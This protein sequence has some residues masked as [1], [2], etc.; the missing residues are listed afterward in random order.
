[1]RRM[2]LWATL[3]GFGSLSFASWAPA[4]AWAQGQPEEE[5]PPPNPY[6]DRAD[7][8][9]DDDADEDVRD[10]EGAPSP[11]GDAAKAEKDDLD[12]FMAADDDDDDDDDDDGFMAKG[13]D[14]DDDD[15]DDGGFLKDL[16][17]TWGGRIQT[18]L[19]FRLEEK[20]VG[21]FYNRASLPVG[22]E[23]NENLFGIRMNA[24][25]GSVLAVA[26]LDF[27]L[28]GALSDVKSIGDLSRGEKLDPYRFDIHR[29][30]VQVKDLVFDGLDL[31]IGQQLILWGAGDQF[32]PTNNLNADDIEDVLLF[33]EQRGN[34]MVRLDYW[35][36]SDWSI[37]GVMVPVFRPAFL[38]RSSPLALANPNRLPM[39]DESVRHRIH[40]E[41]AAGATLAGYPTVVKDVVPL[42]PDTAIENIQL[43]Y[44]IGGSIGGQDVAL[45]YYYGRHDFPV[46]INN[47]IAVAQDPMCNPDDPNECINGRLETTAFV[48][49]PRMHVYGFNMSG[50]VGIGYRLEAALVVP[51]RVE[52]GIT[53]D[54]LDLGVI[55][56]PA[57]EYDYDG[58]NRPGGPKPVVIDDTPFAKWTVGVDYTF[59]EHLY[60]NAQWVH[61]LANEYGAGDWITEGY[62][63]RDGGVTSDAGGTINCAQ[64]DRD[65]T[66]CAREILRNRIADYLVLGVDLNFLDRKLLLRLFT[67]L[68]L[69]GV[70]ETYYDTATETR[71]K[72]HHHL[73]TDEGY[74]VVLY[75]E[76]N[77]N[78][79]NGLELGAGALIQLGKD[80]GRFGA[81]EAGG[82][83]AF[84]RARFSF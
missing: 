18:D 82:S 48:H 20:A 58:D 35:L 9:D 46:P 27:V 41:N 1:M 44:R 63:V 75:P 17:I 66:K 33:G 72:K 74:G 24:N 84:T 22:I 71:V 25:Y 37:T 64:I 39:L 6:G 16:E 49:Y 69:V 13:N 31:T 43:S 10:V 76:V 73:F 62:E 11:D 38:P 42:V 52:M 12:G 2:W 50:E 59:N 19:R 55:V 32:N 21:N 81:P 51:E 78:F 28:Y 45:S 60:V 34:F 23:R 57:G 56:V 30:Y 26:E 8:T 36:D 40:A 79:G 3:L 65:G 70:T 83:L 80:T 4:V 29:L 5:S 68:D 67:I 47:H 15:D 54:E 61:G 53:N 77:Y 14:D 7:A